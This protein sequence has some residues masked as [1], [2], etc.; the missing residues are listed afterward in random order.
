M[1][2]VTLSKRSASKGEWRLDGLLYLAC[3]QAFGAYLNSCYLAIDQ[4]SY[5]FQVR[6]EAP[7]AYAG[8]A[9]SH[10]ALLLSEAP[11]LYSTAGRRP[12]AAYFT[13]S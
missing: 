5:Y 2:S 4:S 6:Q 3:F 9:L 10:A 8:D 1:L 13:N 11:T 12:F 7:S